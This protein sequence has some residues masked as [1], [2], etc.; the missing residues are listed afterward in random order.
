MWIFVV[1]PLDLVGISLGLISGQVAIV[2][3]G[4]CFLIWLLNKVPPHLRPLLKRTSLL[5]FGLL[6][7]TF[8]LV[9]SNLP[10]RLA[11]DA[12]RLEFEQLLNNPQVAIN[13]TR[14][15]HVHRECNGR[16]TG[17]A[18]AIPFEQHVG[19]FFVNDYAADS[20]GGLYFRVSKYLPLF[21]IDQ[22]S[23][24][25]VTHPNPH[26]T[27]FGAAWYELTPIEPVVVPLLS[28]VDR[29]NEGTDRDRDNE[30]HHDWHWFCVSD[31]YY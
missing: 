28:K 2:V 10:F 17:F 30:Q 3:A 20:R 14:S 5:I 15:E 1:W 27:P 12:S 9:H 26:A 29:T 31:D 25:F 23:C 8:G 7:C 22:F 18:V 21:S 6:L 24:G 19:M 16:C 4:I 11:F 13:L